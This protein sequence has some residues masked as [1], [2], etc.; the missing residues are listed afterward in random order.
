MQ[1][2]IIE[3]LIGMF[4][5]M[6]LAFTIFTVYLTITTDKSAKSDI[7]GKILWHH[8]LFWIIIMIWT[9][10]GSAVIIMSRFIYRTLGL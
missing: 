6:Y 4:L 8:G 7:V 2:V 9:C 1:E 3:V 5:L 10:I